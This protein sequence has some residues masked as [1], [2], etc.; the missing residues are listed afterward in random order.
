MKYFILFFLLIINKNIFAFELSCLFEE[1]HQNGDSH[2][3]VII[4]KTRNLGINISLIT[5]ILLYIKTI[6]LFMCRTVIRP[7]FLKINN[8][9]EIL[10]GIVSI[11]E[12]YPN[13]E[14]EYY[15]DRSTI[16]VEYSATKKIIKRII[17]LS[18][19]V[20]MSVYFQECKNP[21]IKDFYFSWS[22]LLGL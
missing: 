18:N 17:I 7:S 21:D 2:Q 3:G 5:S 9:S 6:Y 14:K 20:N 10:E 8:N 22:P 1:V 4:I 13:I 12:D 16:K 19:E 11:I 15:I